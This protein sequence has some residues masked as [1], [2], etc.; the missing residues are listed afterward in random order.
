MT[1]DY[2]TD[3]VTGEIAGVPAEEWPDHVGHCLEALRQG[4]MCASD[5]R[6]V[7]SRMRHDVRLITTYVQSRRVAMGR[8]GQP[9]FD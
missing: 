5:I 3:P 6:Q 7:F 2:Y 1:P 4:I 9:C 8:S